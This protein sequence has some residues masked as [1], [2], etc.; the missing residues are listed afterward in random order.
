VSLKADEVAAHFGWMAMFAD[1]DMPASNAI[2]RKKLA[3][4]PVGPGLI[5]DLDR[6]VHRR[7]S[8][9]NACACVFA[10]AW[11]RSSRSS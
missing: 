7:P 10:G 4:T 1:L 11:D 6:L 5:A 2:T 9:I 3:W 8:G